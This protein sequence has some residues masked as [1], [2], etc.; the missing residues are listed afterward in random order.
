MFTSWSQVYEAES[1]ARWLFV[2]RGC[3]VL[4]VPKRN[5]HLVK[6]SYPTDGRYL[7][8]VDRRQVAPSKYFSSLFEHVSTIDTSP[9]LCVP[10]ALKFRNE[11]CG[12]EEQIRSYCTSLAKQGGELMASLMGTEVLKMKDGTSHE[13]CFTNVRLPLDVQ[14]QNGGAAGPRRS[15]GI[16]PEDAEAV[17]NWITERSVNEFNSYIAVRYYAGGFWTRL[18]AQVYLERT[19][20]VWAAGVLLELCGRA[21]RGDWKLD[22]GTASSSLPEY[23]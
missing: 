12:G 1:F 19:D 21:E 16:C 23:R 8:E 3:S 7:P 6:T 5:Q 11:V 18:S 20:F 4:Y 13:C 17:A 2:P 9:Y 22:A 14:E 15:N 10:E